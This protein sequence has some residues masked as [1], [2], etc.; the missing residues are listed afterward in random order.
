MSLLDALLLGV[1]QGL[2]EFLPVS[3]SGHL[4]IAQTLLGINTSAV[5]FD[6]AMHL[7]TLLAVVIYF[8]KD[9][10]AVA[11][12]FVRRGNA[13]PEA[14]AGT[15]SGADAAAKR[16][17][18]WYILAGTVPAGVAGVLFQ[19][20]F[21]SLFTSVHLVGWTLIGTGFILWLGELAYGGRAKSAAA[22]SRLNKRGLERITL[23]DALLVGIGQAVAIVPGISR[24]GTTIGAGL[25][26]GLKRDAAARFS[27]LLSIPAILGAGLL[28]L[29]AVVQ[30]GFDVSLGVFLVG[31]LAAFVSGLAAIATL[32]AVIKRSHLAWF[33]VYVWIVGLLILVFFP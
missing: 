20:W 8:W 26:V 1:V 13:G 32:L 18:F 16:R 25:A 21:E 29:K 9:L 30:S 3:S 2:T 11:A 22:K 24:S 28:Q 15:G 23:T 6:V 12:A 7:A 31:G 33:S 5:T 19:D 10:S 17:L 27:F 14:R 4:V